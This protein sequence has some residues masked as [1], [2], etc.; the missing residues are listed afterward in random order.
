MKSLKEQFPD[1]PVRAV[2][3]AGQLLDLMW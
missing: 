1:Q 3:K 2:N